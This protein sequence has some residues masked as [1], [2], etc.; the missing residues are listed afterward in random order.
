MSYT[1][2]FGSLDHLDDLL[3]KYEKQ[4]ETLINLLQVRSRSVP[5]L[6]QNNSRKNKYRGLTT[7][8]YNDSFLYTTWMIYMFFF[9]ILLCLN[10][11]L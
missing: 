1:I 5:I 8:H 3:L 2:K 6:D 10:Q 7:S 9:V 11:E 4:C